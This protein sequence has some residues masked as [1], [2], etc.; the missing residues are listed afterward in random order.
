[1]W[2]DVTQELGV[3]LFKCLFTC[4]CVSIET[5]VC[6]KRTFKAVKRVVARTWTVEQLTDDPFVSPFSFLF[7]WFLSLT[8]DVLSFRVHLSKHSEYYLHEVKQT[9]THTQKEKKKR[10]YGSHS[11]EEL[12]TEK[13]R[14]TCPGFRDACSTCCF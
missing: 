8:F 4:V 13:Q 10:N 1:M 9:H 5:F 14:E 6:R 11:N 7:L 2:V 12:E 3:S